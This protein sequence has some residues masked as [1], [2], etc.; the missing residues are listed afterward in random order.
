MLLP[1]KLT[2]SDKLISTFK[3]K[4]REKFPRE[5]YAVLL[6]HGDL[7]TGI[8]IEDIHFPDF[9]ST[10]DCVYIPEDGYLEIA[11]Q[12]KEQDMIICGDIHSHPYEHRED[13]KYPDCSRSELDFDYAPAFM[14]QGICR[15]TQSATGRLR[16][17]VRFWG[18]AVPILVTIT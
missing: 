18:P 8:V 12:A 16:C 17:V 7:A 5:A 9:A 14:V 1:A 3:A 6:G 4:A 10:S 13:G 2:I 11:E 15:V